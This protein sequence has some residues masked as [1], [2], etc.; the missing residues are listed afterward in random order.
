MKLVR[1]HINERFEEESDPI[2]D[3]GIGIKYKIREYF[4]K[5]FSMSYEEFINSVGGKQSMILNTILEAGK[6]DFIKYILDDLDIDLSLKYTDEHAYILGNAAFN[7]DWKGAKFLISQ[8][9][10]LDKT[11]EALEK[12]QLKQTCKDLLY[13]KNLLNK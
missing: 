3:M 7:H 2:Q 6:Y 13:L 1:E 9:A 5:N 8:G 11:I 12:K 4:D 10:D